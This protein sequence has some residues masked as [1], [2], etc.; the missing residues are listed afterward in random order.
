M[1]KLRIFPCPKCNEDTWHRIKKATAVRKGGG[2]YT[3]YQ[4][5]RCCK[6]SYYRRDNMKGVKI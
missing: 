2:A 6:C 5:Y 4:A 1:T 3:K